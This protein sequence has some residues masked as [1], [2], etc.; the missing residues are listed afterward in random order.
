[1]SVVLTDVPHSETR[2][3]KE[4]KTALLEKSSAAAQAEA[5]CEELAS[6]KQELSEEIECHA[7]TVETMEEQL[8]EHEERISRDALLRQQQDNDE[9]FKSGSFARVNGESSSQPDFVKKIQQD[10]YLGDGAP[11]TLSESLRSKGHKVR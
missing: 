2:Q 5:R 10:H 9:D 6:A 4:H 8:T 3:K 11:K 1:M 7:M